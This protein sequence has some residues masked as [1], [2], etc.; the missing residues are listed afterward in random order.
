MSSLADASAFSRREA[1]ALAPALLEGFG[2]LFGLPDPVQRFLCQDLTT[3][4]AVPLFPNG[5]DNFLRIFFHFLSNRNS[6]HCTGSRTGIQGDSVSFAVLFL[7]PFFTARFRFFA[8]S[9][10][11]ADEDCGAQANSKKD[12]TSS[13]CY[14]KFI[15]LSHF[16]RYNKNIPSYAGRRH[17]RRKPGAFGPEHRLPFLWTG[18][19]WKGGVTNM[20]SYRIL[21]AALA[22]CLLLGLTACGKKGKPLPPG[23]RILSGVRFIL[24]RRERHGACFHYHSVCGCARADRSPDRYGAGCERQ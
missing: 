8:R 24:R 11:L 13:K 14:N 19:I 2:L 23:S 6:F 10:P 7:F 18:G 17:H 1:P 12:D 9:A 4:S 3:C 20:K 21:S 16:S 5:N 22:L 15:L